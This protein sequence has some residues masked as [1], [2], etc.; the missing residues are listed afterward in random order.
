MYESAR[1]MVCALYLIFGIILVVVVLLLLERLYQ[2]VG[3]KVLELQIKNVEL[4][5][6]AHR[7]FACCDS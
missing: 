5:L 2:D 1:K 6:H 7:I 3:T 4:V